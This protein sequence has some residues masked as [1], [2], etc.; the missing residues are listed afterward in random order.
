[1]SAKIHNYISNTILTTGTNRL[2]LLNFNIAPGLVYHKVSVNK[3]NNKVTHTYKLISGNEFTTL[4]GYIN[5]ETRLNSTNTI[6]HPSANSNGLSELSNAKIIS[7]L[8]NIISVNKLKIASC[9]I[10]TATQITYKIHGTY[11]FHEF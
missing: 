4:N 8:G 10:K 11:K 5:N 1:M 6:L 3:T 9:Q 7:I 2:K